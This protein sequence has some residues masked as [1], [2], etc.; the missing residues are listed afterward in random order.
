VSA[1]KYRRAVLTAEVDTLLVTICVQIST[2]YEI[3]FLEMG[4]DKDHVH[5]VVQSFPTCSPTQVIRTIKSL[6]AREMHTGQLDL[7]TS[8]GYAEELRAKPVAEQN[9]QTQL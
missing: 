8:T 3:A 2:R 5:F 7:F 6:T 9:G 1:I 4:T